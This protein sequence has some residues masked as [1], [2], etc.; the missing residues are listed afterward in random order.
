VNDESCRPLIDVAGALDQSNF[1]DIPTSAISS[2]PMN[3]QSAISHLQ[4]R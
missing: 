2:D 1:Y 4:C 3:P